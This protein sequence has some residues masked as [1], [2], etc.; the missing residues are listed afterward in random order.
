MA[1]SENSRIVRR[2]NDIAHQLSLYLE[3]DLRNLSYFLNKRKEFEFYNRNPADLQYFA[4]LVR[5]KVAKTIEL[6][7]NSQY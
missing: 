6:Q 7:G 2:N 4:T 3:G 1:L 5:G